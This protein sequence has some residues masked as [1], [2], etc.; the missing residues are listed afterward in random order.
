MKRTTEKG[1]YC[2]KL[3]LNNY[4][5]LN[6]CHLTVTLHPSRDGAYLYSDNAMCGSSV[7]GPVLEGQPPGASSLASSMWNRL[8][9]SPFTFV[10]L[11]FDGLKVEVF[12][13]PAMIFLSL[14]SHPLAAESFD[15]D[16]RPRPEGGELYSLASL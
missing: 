15:I 16:P 4:H 14:L 1:D 13:C 7:T 8:F 11:W 2:S 12:L 6:I 10:H 5:W 3:S 9:P